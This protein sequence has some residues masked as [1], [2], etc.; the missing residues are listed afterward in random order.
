MLIYESRSSK[1]EHVSIVTRRIFVKL[2]KPSRTSF[3]TRFQL[4][5]RANLSSVQIDRELKVKISRVCS[6]LNVDGLRGDIVTNRA[7]KALAAVKGKDRV[8][9]DDVATVIPNC[10][11]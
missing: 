2:T 6:E 11:R 4:L 7:A 3:K 8:T 9:P 1:R 10:L 5:A